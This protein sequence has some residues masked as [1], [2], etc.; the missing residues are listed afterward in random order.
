MRWGSHEQDNDDDE[1]VHVATK[2]VLRSFSYKDQ[3]IGFLDAY[4]GK[5]AGDFMQQHPDT[6]LAY[7]DDVME[8]DDAGLK[9]VRPVRCEWQFR[10]FH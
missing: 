8:T 2:F 10:A 9:A 1:D 5:E 6:A 4:S 7:L 3:S